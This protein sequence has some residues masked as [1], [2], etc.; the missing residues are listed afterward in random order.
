MAG[1]GAF[2]LLQGIVDRIPGRGQGHPA[3]SVCGA[4]IRDAKGIDPRHVY[5]GAPQL[6]SL[7]SRELLPAE[8]SPS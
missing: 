1:G 4:K 8:V 5:D 6:D 2:R 3:L 7:C